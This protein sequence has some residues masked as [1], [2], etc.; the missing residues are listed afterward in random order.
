MPDPGIQPGCP[1]CRLMLYLLR[2]PGSAQCKYGMVLA[3]FSLLTPRTNKGRGCVFPDE[4][5]SSSVVSKSLGPH[6]LYP[7]RLLCSWNSPGKN[8]GVGVLITRVSSQPRDRTQVSCILGG[9]FVPMQISDGVNMCLIGYAQDQSGKGVCF[10][11]IKWK[12]MLL[13]WVNV[14]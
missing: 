6:G 3:C 7:D 2:F 14:L 12:W 5:E 4:R 1:D 13:S 9:F 11:W 10:L 8:T